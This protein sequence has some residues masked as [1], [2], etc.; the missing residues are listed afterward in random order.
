ME[1]I[2]MVK[3]N[4]SF[5]Y[6]FIADGTWFY[7]KATE[8]EALVSGKSKGCSFTTINKKKEVAPQ[9]ASSSISQP[10]GWIYIKPTKQEMDRYYR[11]VKEA[12]NR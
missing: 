4:T 10:T 5:G 6:K 11:K 3:T 12:V 9:G 7:V 2:T 8:L 1:N